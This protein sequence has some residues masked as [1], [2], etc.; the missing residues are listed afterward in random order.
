[1][2]AKRRVL[3]L[4]SRQDVEPSN[5]FH[6]TDRAPPSKLR[7]VR[8]RG[9]RTR[10]HNDDFRGMDAMG[11]FKVMLFASL[12]AATLAATFADA[13]VTKRCA[14]GFHRTRERGIG[15]GPDW[16]GEPTDCRAIWRH[17]RYRGNDP[18]PNIR[19]QLMRGR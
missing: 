16:R 3:R 11:F 13:A 7:P 2:A 8:C 15:T 12:T 10:R 17:G 9:R 4:W 18:D 6:A 5:T 14:T 1:L 19:L